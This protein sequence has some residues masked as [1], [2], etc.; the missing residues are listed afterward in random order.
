MSIFGTV[1]KVVVIPALPF[2]GQM[3]FIFQIAGDWTVAVFAD[4][5]DGGRGGLPANQLRIVVA[6]A[7]VRRRNRVWVRCDSGGN[8]RSEVFRIDAL[9]NCHRFHRLGGDL[10]FW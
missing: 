8:L 3:E 5:F 9:V 7:G 10:Q 1:Y 6:V 2:C 4:G